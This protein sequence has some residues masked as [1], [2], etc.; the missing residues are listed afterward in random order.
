MGASNEKNPRS[1]TAE[2]LAQP[3]NDRRMQI[4]KFNSGKQI[5]PRWFLTPTNSFSPQGVQ[6][7]APPGGGRVRG[8]MNTYKVIWCNPDSEGHVE[9]LIKA[10]SEVMPI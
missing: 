6:V 4:Q 1:F 3:E 9:H 5:R 8:I 10:E 2:F 7:C